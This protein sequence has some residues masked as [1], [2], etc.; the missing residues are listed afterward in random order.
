MLPRRILAVIV[1]YFFLVLQQQANINLMIWYLLFMQNLQ[2]QNLLLTRRIRRRQNR[3]RRRAPY[4]WTL[5]RP[6]ESWFEIHYTDRT[7]PGDYFRRLL[8]MNR[9]SFDL[10][11]NVIRNRLTRQN[12]ILR[13]CLTPE[14]VLACGLLRLAH[15]N[16]YETI[17]PAL[18]VGRTTATEACQDVVEALYEMRNEYIKFPTTVAETMR[19]IE[20]FTDKSRLPNIVGAIDGT[21]IKIISPRDSAVDYFSRNQQ[22]D[23][24]IQA[25]S[26][27]KGLFLDFAA[28]YPGS[29]HD[30]RVYR[31]SSLYQRA[32]NED[33]LREPVERIGITDIR[34]YLVGD[35]AYS[36]SPWLMKPYPEATRDPGEITFNKELSSPRVAI[37]CAFG[38]L[39]S[40]W[41]ILQKRLDSRITFSV[42]I[43]I[44]CAVLH[45]FCINVGD[46]W[47]DD[48]YDYDDDRGNE[49]NNDF[50]QDG[51]DIRELLKDSLCFFFF[52][53][54]GFNCFILRP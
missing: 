53:Q 25:V 46:E 1:F 52:F 31:N 44:A 14:K 4:Y 40:R 8:R 54:T 41:R 9:E 28:G 7:I 23:F 10:L 22:H 48:F 2:T 18:N 13:N 49:Q 17:E 16:S 38:R 45:N 26:D 21:H 42:K 34:P 11:L 27:G 35:S 29:L 6:V 19:C 32:S 50:M 33:I 43:S 24:I 51:E 39:K 20:T 3:Y 37:E 5:P 36:I 15:G 47:E 12:T 30:A